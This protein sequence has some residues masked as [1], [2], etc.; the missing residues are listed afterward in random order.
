[1]YE[2][3]GKPREVEA[4]RVRRSVVS[5]GFMVG[6]LVV[7]FKFRGGFIEAGFVV[8][9]LWFVICDVAEIV[10]GRLFV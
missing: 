10:F 5:L 9:G 7:I 6:L 1:M 4:R 8:C 3:G 2:R